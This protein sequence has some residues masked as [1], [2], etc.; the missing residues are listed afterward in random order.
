M[1]YFIIAQFVILGLILLLFNPLTGR[2][3]TL[4]YAK[5]HGIDS[6]IFYRQIGTESYFRCFIK[7]NKGAMGIG[8]VIY[9]TA[10]YMEKDIKQWELYLPWKNLD[11]S[12]KYMR[13]LLKR[14][15][16]NYSLALAAYNWGETNIDTVLKANNVVIE[17]EEDYRYLFANVRETYAYL[18]KI[19][20]P[21]QPSPTPQASRGRQ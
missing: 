1:R 14:Y 15:N 2:L 10:V 17:T 6:G 7:S 21:T 20:T 11:I 9:S 4:Y 12:A 16:N 8:Q 5:K 18:E 13:Y 19:T 3:M